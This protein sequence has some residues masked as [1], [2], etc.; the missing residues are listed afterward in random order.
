MYKLH[1][2]AAVYQNANLEIPSL[3]LQFLNPVLL[4]VVVALKSYV[5]KQKKSQQFHVK[6]AG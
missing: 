2:L 4:F 3:C 6:K 1:S 5:Q